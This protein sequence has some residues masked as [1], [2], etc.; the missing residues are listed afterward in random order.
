MTAIVVVVVYCHSHPSH[1]LLCPHKCRLPQLE[2]TVCSSSNDVEKVQGASC[3]GSISN[4]VSDWEFRSWSVSL[5]TRHYE[6]PQSKA[7]EWHGRIFSSSPS[8][9]FSRALSSTPGKPFDTV[10]SSNCGLGWWR[11]LRKGVVAFPEAS[12]TLLPWD[13][14]PL[15]LSLKSGNSFVFL[16]G[17]CGFKTRYFHLWYLQ[18]VRHPLKAL[19]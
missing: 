9:P 5:L 19:L 15:F 18:S 1:L 2:T 16:G 6:L 7:S 4:P 11:A 13:N 17:R 8:F 14:R 12:Q 3:P 10:Q